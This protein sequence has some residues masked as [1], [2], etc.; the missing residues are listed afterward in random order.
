MHKIANYFLSILIVAGLTG[1]GNSHDPVKQRQNDVANAKELFK[2]LRT[3]VMG[4]VKLDDNGSNG[5]FDDE[6]ATFGHSLE[7]VMLNVDLVGKYTAAI[8]QEIIAVMKEE[9]EG[10]DVLQ[11]EEGRAVN[12][13]QSEDLV[14]WDYNIT[15]DGDL[16]GRGVVTM[17]DS[18]LSALPFKNSTEV[19]TSITGTFPL[20]RVGEE[21][22]PGTQSAILNLGLTQVSDGA[23]LNISRLSIANATAQ[24]ALSDFI[25]RAKYEEINSI[26]YIIFDS[27]KLKAL[28]PGYLYEGTLSLPEANYV[29]NDTFSGNGGKVPSRLIFNGSLKDLNTNARITGNLQLDWLD[30]A[31]AD[32]S[33]GSN[34]DMHLKITLGGVLE[35]TSY[36]DTMITIVSEDQVDVPGRKLNA[37]Y[38]YGSTNVNATG[39]FDREMQNGT[40]VI[41]TSNDIKV[42]LKITNGNLMY[43]NQSYVQ[44]GDTIIGNMEE[45]NGI[46]VVHYSDGTFES[47]Q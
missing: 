7:G 35:R 16:L 42:V 40:L 6:A 11:V 32:L 19:N 2:N 3:Q 5:F 1:C 43:G 31:T 41:T 23:V 20:H 13:Q 24:I 36:Q 21:T 25:I 33:N 39:H 28:V 29:D 27:T 44:K 22:D 15:Q 8:V 12:L 34:P 10:P 45:R 38:Q 26:D 30:A 47:L 17:P 37:S 46:V 4:L 9:K 14:T 18:N